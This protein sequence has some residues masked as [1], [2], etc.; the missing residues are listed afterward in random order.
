MVADPSAAVMACVEALYTVLNPSRD[1]AVRLFVA[2]CT[3]FSVLG[4]TRPFEWFVRYPPGR[5]VTWARL[6][7]RKGAANRSLH[8]ANSFSSR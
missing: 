4:G 8:I 1:E 5:P 7:V 6:G 3:G 2:T